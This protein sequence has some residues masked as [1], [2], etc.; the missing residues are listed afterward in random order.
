MNASCW[1]GQGTAPCWAS[2][3][4]LCLL[5]A[6]PCAAPRGLP[7]LCLALHPFTVILLLSNPFVRAGRPPF[8]ARNTAG[9]EEFFVTSLDAWRREQGLEKM[10][11]VGWQLLV[12]MLCLHLLL[13]A[14]DVHVACTQCSI[15]R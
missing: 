4:G 13:C 9:A 11:L 8:K 14:T 5:S 15:R 1:A 10:V 6:L 12:R 2:A 7:R 3:A